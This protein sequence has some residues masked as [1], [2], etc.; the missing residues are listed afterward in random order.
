MNNNNKLQRSN[1]S[2]GIQKQNNNDKDLIKQQQ[3]EINRLNKQLENNN[4]IQQSNNYNNINNSYGVGNYEYTKFWKTYVFIFAILPIIF[5]CTIILFFVGILISLVG[6][7][8]AT[9]P[10]LLYWPFGRKYGRHLGNKLW[11]WA[12]YVYQVFYIIGY[13]VLCFALL[14]LVFV[15]SVI[16]YHKAVANGRTDRVFNKYNN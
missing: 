10:S 13:V 11:V 2:T 14:P 6:I 7:F 15:P 1:T 16:K 9:L 5:C 3:E 4:S 12:S 8:A